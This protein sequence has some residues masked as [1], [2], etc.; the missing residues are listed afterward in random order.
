M[1]IRYVIYHEYSKK[2]FYS[3]STKA[4]IAPPLIELKF[5]LGAENTTKDVGN[6][7]RIIILITDEKNI[8]VI[9]QKKEMCIA[10]RFLL[11]WEFSVSL[12]DKME[13]VEDIYL[14]VR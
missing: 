6:S 1:P 12:Q 5:A 2:N 4:A 11:E 9:N 13:R 14:K 3:N 7:W 8:R 10:N